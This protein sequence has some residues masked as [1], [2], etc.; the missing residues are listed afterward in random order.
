MPLDVFFRENIANEIRSART[1][2]DSALLFADVELKKIL[3]EGEPQRVVEAIEHL[4]FYRQGY[5]AALGAVALAFGI[6]PERGK[7]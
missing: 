6:L 3:Q 2:S 4:D 5:E 1:A 7:P